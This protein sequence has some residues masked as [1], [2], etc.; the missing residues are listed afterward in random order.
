MTVEELIDA[1]SYF[2]PNMKVAFQACNSM[3]VDAISSLDIKEV[4]RFYGED[5]DYLII[6]SDGQIGAV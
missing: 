6:F 1:L 4:R 5:K 3:Y 2:D